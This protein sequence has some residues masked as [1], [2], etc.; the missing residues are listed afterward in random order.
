MAKTIQQMTASEYKEWL[1][2]NPEEAKKLDAPAG[3]PALTPTGFW[4]NGVWVKYEPNTQ[5]TVNGVIR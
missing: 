2:A 3:A 1:A 4:R 5:T